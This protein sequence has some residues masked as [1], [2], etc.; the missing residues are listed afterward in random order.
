MMSSKLI[1]DLFCSIM[2]LAVPENRNRPILAVIPAAIFMRCMSP[3]L[4]SSCFQKFF[5]SLYCSSSKLLTVLARNLPS[6]SNLNIVNKSA[7]GRVSAVCMVLRN[8]YSI[9][10]PPLSSPENILRSTDI[11]DSVIIS[12]S[13]NS[14][15]P[16]NPDVNSIR[17]MPIG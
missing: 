7:S 8:T 16:S 15:S 17:L 1:V 3:A 6:F 5:R 14:S 2:P 10:C 12:F 11:V 9:R 13:R 4:P